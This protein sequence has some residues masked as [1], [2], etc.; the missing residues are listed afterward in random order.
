MCSGADFMDFLVG[1]VIQL[2]KVFTL[3]VEQPADLFRAAGH[4]EIGV[5]LVGDLGGLAVQHSVKAVD[6]LTGLGDHRAVRG[7]A[8]VVGVAQ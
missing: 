6:R 7:L 8:H 5:G 4:R 1:V 2:V 3:A